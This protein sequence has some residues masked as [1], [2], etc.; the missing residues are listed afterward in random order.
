MSS[1]APTLGNVRR[2]VVALCGGLWLSILVTLPA[3]ADAPGWPRQ[4]E[5]SSGSFVVY[6]P[7]PE[8][9][10]GDRIS[11]RAAFALES[12]GGNPAFGV[13]WFNA[14][15]VVDRDSSTVTM[16]N[17]DV[18]KVRLPGITPEQESRY[19]SLIESEAAGWDLT[20][21]LSELQ[22]GLASA[23]QERA[24]VADLNN[25]PPKIVFKEERTLLLLYDGAPF[26]EPIEGTHLERVANTPFAVVFDPDS[27]TYY[28][29]G[30]NL[31]YSASDPLGPWSELAAPPAAVRSVV[32]PDTVATDRVRG[33]SPR[34]LVAT[35]P[36]ELIAID[37][38]PRYAPL[39]GDD[40]LY[41]TNTES[42]VVR[43]VGTQDLYVLIAGRWYRSHSTDGPWTYLRGDQLPG[44]FR[45][46]PPHSPKGHLLA[47]IPGTDQADDAVADAEIP[48]TS[49]IRRGIVDFQVGYDGPPQF[50]P[51]AGTDLEYAVNTNA[52]VILADG[53]YYACDQGVWYVAD[54]PEGPWSVS[55]VRPIGVDQIP[56]SYPVYDLRYVYVY[57]ATPDFVYMGYLPGYMGCYP[58]DG[59]VVYGTGY[60]YHSWRRHHYYAWPC[61]WGFYARY[62][63]RYSRW[64]FGTS[65]GVPF[66]RTGTRWGRPPQTVYR[67]ASARWFGPGGYRRPSLAVTLMP[68]GRNQAMAPGS[69]RLPLNLYSRSPNIGRSGP[70]GGLP[71]LHA[72]RPERAARP[73][74]RELARPND[75]YAGQDGKVYQRDTGGHWRVNEGRIWRPARVPDLPRP[76]AVGVGDP[77][78]P[79]YRAPVYRPHPQP[80]PGWTTD[81]SAVMR[82]RA[83][84]SPPR[85][86]P[87]PGNLERE[88]RGRERAKQQKAGAPT[89]GE[90]TPAPKNASN[91]SR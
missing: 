33:A 35:E 69:D 45:R 85:I 43:E 55:D 23:E 14:K 1:L 70:P 71:P 46:I 24:S 52:E 12:A 91:Q 56:P 59:T 80:A 84:A 72:A 18:T 68:R 42:D 50:E 11:G 61:T 76:S 40:L 38:P 8:R 67:V 44:Y 19:E 75:V 48:Q 64:G 66:L 74:P 89:S 25:A 73:V 3:R 9:L 88:F 13:L 41:V 58:Y 87:T 10:D 20:G 17:L 28:L 86:R 4:F 62:D 90:A 54:D 51:I 27:H 49:A 79:P 82:S 63:P 5:S 16:S 60:H 81:P 29:N 39:V 53:R 32:P 30:A 83:P 36:T 77:T 57:G 7:E 26:L 21:S 78:A 37:G 34:V 31:W 22:A 65:Y 15:I 6:Q 47:S 2:S